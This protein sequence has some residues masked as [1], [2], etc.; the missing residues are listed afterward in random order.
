MILE[1]KCWK[2]MFKIVFLFNIICLGTIPSSIGSLTSIT[3]LY[4]YNNKLIGYYKFNYVCFMYV[5]IYGWLSGTIPSSIGSLTKLI[6][7]YLD[8]NSLNGM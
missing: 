4:F 7:L 5:H 1:S 6:I 8:H 3:E 2:T